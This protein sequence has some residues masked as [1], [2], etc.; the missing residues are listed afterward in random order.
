MNKITPKLRG[1][2][3]VMCLLTAIQVHAQWSTVKAHVTGSDV[4]K[5]SG[6]SFHDYKGIASGSF[7]I[8]ASVSEVRKKGK[9]DFQL[10]VQSMNMVSYDSYAYHPYP[11]VNY[12]SPTDGSVQHRQWTSDFRAGDIGADV[13]QQAR[14]SASAAFDV[15]IVFTVKDEKYGIAGFGAKK[16]WGYKVSRIFKNVTGNGVFWADSPVETS[17]PIEDLKILNQPKLVAF[18]ANDSAIQMAIE[19]YIKEKNKQIEEQCKEKA[20]NKEDDQLKKDEE[21]QKAEASAK[22]IENMKSKLQSQINIRSTA[23]SST[24]KSSSEAKS[25]NDFWAGG[26]DDGANNDDFWSGGKDKSVAKDGT[27]NIEA[28]NKDGRMYL[29]D[30][31]DIIKEWSRDQYYGISQLQGSNEF[32]VLEG[33]RQGSG[34]LSQNT[35]VIVDKQ[36]KTVRIDGEEAFGYI[37]PREE[38]GYTLVK[39]ISQS[40]YEGELFNGGWKP[41]DSY[42][43]SSEAVNDVKSNIERIV[44]ERRQKAIRENDKRV[45]IGFME[46][47]NVV[48][49]KEIITNS[50][51]Q[52]LI[53]KTHYK[54]R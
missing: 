47:Y 38:G 54:V 50:K 42:T 16:G 40:L 2:F 13:F 6:I 53:T 39:Y 36:G 3:G 8:I 11:E 48:E 22:E 20:K 30:S 24:A 1:I 27:S 35:S 44:E 9:V 17:A 32:F 25:Q 34:F 49:V 28:V 29:K 15:E 31:Y 14:H 18:K 10:H 23:T 41:R 5:I 43:S 7:E 4:M 33:I 12:C 46:K 45:S 51:M 19:N 26:N 37:Y 52:A 21:H